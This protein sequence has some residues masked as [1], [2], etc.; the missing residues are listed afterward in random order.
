[1]A[2][3]LWAAFDRPEAGTEELAE[4]ALAHLRSQLLGGQF[5]AVQDDSGHTFIGTPEEATQHM[6]GDARG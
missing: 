4:M 5:V 3:Q 6:M 1:M 2:R